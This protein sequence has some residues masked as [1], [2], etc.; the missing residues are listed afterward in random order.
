[1]NVEKT[2]WNLFKLMMVL[3]ACALVYIP[4][5]II[6]S[7]QELVVNSHPLHLT[8][9]EFETRTGIAL[10]ENTV[11]LSAVT[12]PN[13]WD[14]NIDV[15]LSIPVDEYDA[16]I[17]QFDEQ[18]RT[19]KYGDEPRNFELAYLKYDA[20][21]LIASFDYVIE[22]VGGAYLDVYCMTNTEESVDCFIQIRY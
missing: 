15:K 8:N 19:R 6:K 21:N 17:I 18:K 5:S 12:I 20:N 10:T 1:M 2:I 14:S 13:S 16:F 3:F 7:I 4:Y 9:V 11:I 22:S